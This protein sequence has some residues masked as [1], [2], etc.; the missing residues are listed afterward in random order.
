MSF[1]SGPPDVGQ[2][3][4]TSVLTALLCLCEWCRVPSPVSELVHPLAERAWAD[5]QPA[6]VMA[7]FLLFISSLL[8]V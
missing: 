6:C 4:I 1:T 7:V 3:A 5:H 2:G 8:P